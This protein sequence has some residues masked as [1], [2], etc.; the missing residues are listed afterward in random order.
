M[1][2]LDEEGIAG[3]PG[4]S[5]GFPTP[6]KEGDPEAQALSSQLNAVEDHITAVVGFDIHS[7]K[8]QT[9]VDHVVAHP[10]RKDGVRG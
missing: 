8:A 5:A 2:S 10:E 6:Y 4:V 7:K 3:E 1:S 9:G